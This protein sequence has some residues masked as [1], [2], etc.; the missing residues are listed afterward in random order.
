M[1]LWVATFTYSTISISA[2]DIEIAKNHRIQAMACFKMPEHFFDSLLRGTVGVYRTL[3]RIFADYYA[4]LITVGCTCRKN[5]EV[6][7]A[8][9]YRRF[10]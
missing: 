1:G 8:S 2:R 9:S 7:Y 6:L 3:G 5:D 4:I 10:L